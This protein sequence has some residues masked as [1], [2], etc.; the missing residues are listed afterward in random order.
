[1]NAAAR[2]L[3]FAPRGLSRVE[4]SRYIGVGPTLFDEMVKDGRMPSAKKINSRAV[5]DR[6]ELDVYFEAL[7][8]VAPK[9]NDPFAFMDD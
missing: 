2:P 4:A 5:W 7:P 6:E 3:P 9:G 8:T 1:M